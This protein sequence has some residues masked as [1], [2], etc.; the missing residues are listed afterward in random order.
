MIAPDIA[1]ATPADRTRVVA[2]LVAAFSTDPILRWLFPAD[3]TYPQHAAV[4]FGHLFDRR[5]G[6]G[7]TWIAEGGNAVAIW[8]PPA[9]PAAPGDD[10]AQRFP[11]EV[12]ARVHAYD[13]A[14][15][16]VLPTT[17]HWYLGVLGTHPDHTGRRLGHAVM[18]QGLRRAAAAGL[19]AVLETASPG[20]VGM[21]ERAG[22]RVIASAAEPLPF[23]VLSQ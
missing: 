1:L 18:A 5:V 16:A 15:R 4:F 11:P 19:P 10:L 9:A 6:L 13:Q 7:A 8:Q 14:L 3:D 21:Y 20:N 12:R 2:S 17:P 23:W 22:W